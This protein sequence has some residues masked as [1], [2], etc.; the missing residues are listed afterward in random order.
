M[1]PRE[2]VERVQ[3]QL[4][5]ER[6]EHLSA[7]LLESAKS[8]KEDCTVI[9]SAQLFGE[10]EPIFDRS[11]VSSMNQHPLSFINVYIRF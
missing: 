3:T 1:Q 8:N 6:E 4:F 9:L 10:E 7:S 5:L 2:R 11:L